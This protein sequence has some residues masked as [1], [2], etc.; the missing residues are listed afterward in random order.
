MS[1][2]TDYTDK[3]EA[4]FSD[5][6]SDLVTIKTNSADVAQQLSDLKAQLANGNLSDADKAALAKVTSD[7]ADLATASDEAA[8]KVA[9]PPAP[10]QDSSGGQPAA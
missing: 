2:I 8:G 10:A 4:A 9:A 5:I 3:V 1:Q 7:A 6:K